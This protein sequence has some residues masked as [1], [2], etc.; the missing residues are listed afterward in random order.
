M[1]L[2]TEK[3]AAIGPPCWR[4]KPADGIEPPTPAFSGLLGEVSKPR[5]DQRK[6]LSTGS[7]GDAGLGSF[8][9]NWDHF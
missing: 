3:N 2:I 8:R 9:T 7:L 1:T 5:R 6:L 4:F